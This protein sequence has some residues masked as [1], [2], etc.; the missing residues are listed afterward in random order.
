MDV[1]DRGPRLRRLD[2]GGRDLLGRD[3]QVRM[4]IGPRDAAGHRAGDDGLIRHPLAPVL[5]PGEQHDAFDRVCNTAVRTIA[6]QTM[7][8][9]VCRG[10][11]AAAA[12]R[13]CREMN[14]ATMRGAATA[15]AAAKSDPDAEPAPAHAKAEADREAH[16]DAP[17]RHGGECHR[18]ARVLEAAERAGTDH[19]A[20]VEDLEQRGD[21]EKHDGGTHDRGIGGIAG[22]DEQADDRGRRRPHHRCHGQHEQG[23]HRQRRD[24]GALDALRMAGAGGQTH[25]HGRGLRQ[26]KWHH[27]GHRGA[28]QC[29][30][31][32]GELGRANQAHEEACA[33]EQP[34]LHDEGHADRQADPEDLP[35]TRPIG[36]PQMP[37]NVKAAELPVDQDEAEQTDEQE[38]VGQRGGDARARKPERR[39]AEAA[40]D[41]AVRGDGVERDADQRDH[42]RR[43]RPL[44]RSDE[45]AQH[46]EPERRPEAPHGGAHVRLGPGDQLEVLVEQCKRDSASVD[47][48]EPAA[49]RY[50]SRSQAAVVGALANDWTG[51]TRT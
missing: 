27:E 24:A 5:G 7:A 40:K 35:K 30:L 34:D 45:V 16:A 51:P 23:A 48:G 37:E 47:A 25:A 12:S 49:A 36:P 14:R 15:S 22:I 42:H 44:Q 2:R 33:G 19:L 41:Q 20:A 50:H 13:R 46:D 32:R 6:A 29:D 9:A 8:S 1:D 18:P 43:P 38:D 21:G 28:L 10:A 3:R 17:V 26:A 11:G 4:L 31:V 39:Q